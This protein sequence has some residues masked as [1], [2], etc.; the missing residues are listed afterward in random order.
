VLKPI[1]SPI[2]TIRAAYCLSLALIL[3]ACASQP[4]SG[5]P[6]P[7]QL[8]KMQVHHL[9]VVNNTKQVINV[10]KYKPCGADAGGFQ[11]LAENLMPQERVAFNLYD[12]C[13]DVRAVNTFDQTLSEQ[14][15][16]VISKTAV[17]ELQ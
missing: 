1:D 3:A 4:A 17:W 16:L 5:L 12:R 15:G 8:A 9:Q 10:I 14:K 6:T 13:I 2:V 11:T 7:E